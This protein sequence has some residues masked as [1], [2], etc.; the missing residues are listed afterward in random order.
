MLD[1]YTEGRVLRL[2]R[3]NERKGTGFL[4]N[5]LQPGNPYLSPQLRTEVRALFKGL[6]AVAIPHGDQ[7][8]SREETV[9]MSSACSAIASFV[10]TKNQVKT[11]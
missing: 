8:L 10:R 5:A 11:R 3:S 1:A 4:L 7:A 9:L 2:L 6:I